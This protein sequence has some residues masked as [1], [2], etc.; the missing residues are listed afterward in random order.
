MSGGNH[1]FTLDE[2]AGVL[3]R[4]DVLK[5]DVACYSAKERNPGAD[6][7]R[8]ASDNEPLNEPGLEA[9][10]VSKLLRPMTIA[11]TVAMNSS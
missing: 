4:P 11:S 3:P 7:H 10:T 6:E 8:N 5:D 1:V 9:R 2:A